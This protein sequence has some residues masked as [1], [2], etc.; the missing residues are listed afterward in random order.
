MPQQLG[1]IHA[2]TVAL[3]ILASGCLPGPGQGIVDRINAANSP[4]VNEVILLPANPFEGQGDEVQVF[5]L[6][7]ATDADALA[8]WCDVIVP[9]GAA[10]LPAGTVVVYWGDNLNPIRALRNPACSGIESPVS[11]G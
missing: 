10:Q 7:D 3:C 2:T 8:L 11:S 6:K 5:I 4:I 1:R 9:A